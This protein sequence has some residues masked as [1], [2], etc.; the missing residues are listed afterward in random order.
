MI[1]LSYPMLI[2]D[3]N[4]T[5]EKRNSS[6]ESNRYFIGKSIEQR[7]SPSSPKSS[8]SSPWNTSSFLTTR[9]NVKGSEDI[10]CGRNKVP[11]E[12]VIPSPNS[13]S[14]LS[15]QIS[16]SPIFMKKISSSSIDS[17]V[18][19]SCVDDG[20]ENNT[21]TTHSTLN[22]SSSIN[23]DR[24]HHHQHLPYYHHYRHSS[25]TSTSTPSPKS[26]TQQHSSCNK[27]ISRSPQPQHSQQHSF[28][29]RHNNNLISSKGSTSPPLLIGSKSGNWDPIDLY[30][31]RTTDNRDDLSNYNIRKPRCD[32][33]H[34][35][36]KQDNPFYI[37]RQQHDI[38]NRMSPIEQEEYISRST[39]RGSLYT[40]KHQKHHRHY[41]HRY[42]QNPYDIDS[43][44]VVRS[45]SRSL[46]PSPTKCNNESDSDFITSNRKIKNKSLLDETTTSTG[47][48]ITSRHH[49]TSPSSPPPPIKRT[50]SIRSVKDM[51]KSKPTTFDDDATLK[52]QQEQQESGEL[53]NTHDVSKSML[54]A[55]L[56]TVST[57]TT[58]HQL[59][60]GNRTR[61]H[62]HRYYQERSRRKRDE[63]RHLIPQ[64][65]SP[66]PRSMATAYMMESIRPHIQGRFYEERHTSSHQQSSLCTS[67][68]CC[69]PKTS[70]PPSTATAATPHSFLRYPPP[71]PQPRHHSAVI[72]PPT[73]PALH[74]SGPTLPPTALGTAGALQF[75]HHPHHHP[76]HPYFHH[77]FY[78]RP[79]YYGNFF[80]HLFIYLFT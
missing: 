6:A 76:H 11:P 7:T 1:K 17:S 48:V 32:I 60:H 9:E 70:P 26:Q 63:D 35:N 59:E 44:A 20:C 3:R 33:I 8:S 73:L 23:A 79:F 30:M 52:K 55:P 62:H 64:R 38:N 31:E 36:A 27:V 74:V 40:E 29:A 5:I 69:E 49:D 18:P 72:P 39:I 56:L 4:M 65:S 68:C 75:K 53:K 77:N 78:A 12:D 45:R 22:R 66:P 51:I 46:V 43:S 16:K 67:D 80:I 25:S 28:S 13:S 10:I 37:K 34:S 42:Y 71:P 2:E 58:H 24:D 50:S 21:L 14:P 57:T 15:P 47:S 41:Y 61:K 19:C 54:S